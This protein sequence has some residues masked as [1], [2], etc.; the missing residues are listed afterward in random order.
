MRDKRAAELDKTNLLDDFLYQSTD[1]R[2]IHVEYSRT[3]AARPECAVLELKRNCKG[4][5][6]DSNQCVFGSANS[7]ISVSLWR[8][9]SILCETFST[10]ETNGANGLSASQRTSQPSLRTCIQFCT[11]TCSTVTRVHFSSVFSMRAAVPLPPDRK[12][13]AA[14]GTRLM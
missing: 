12:T 11:E 10:R 1:R 8:S 3:K 4:A 9:C 6:F 5:A 7:E 2:A 14:R 13:A